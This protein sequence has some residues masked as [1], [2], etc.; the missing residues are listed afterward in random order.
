LQKPAL[1]SI[2]F[3]LFSGIKSVQMTD[4]TVREEPLDSSIVSTLRLLEPE[5]GSLNSFVEQLRTDRPLEVT[6]TPPASSDPTSIR[7]E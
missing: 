5:A 2:T 7:P 3:D 4:G 1:K 6:V